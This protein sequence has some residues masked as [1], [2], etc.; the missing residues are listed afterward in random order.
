MSANSVSV[1]DKD[2]QEEVRFYC[3]NCNI[4]LCDDCI[5]GPHKNH[6]FIKLQEFGTQKKK[7]KQFIKYFERYEK[8]PKFRKLGLRF[9]KMQEKC[10][11]IEDIIK[12]IESKGTNLLDTDVALYHVALEKLFEHDP[13]YETVPNIQQLNEEIATRNKL[14]N[15]MGHMDCGKYEVVQPI[16]EETIP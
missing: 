4:T 5:T 13:Y 16:E 8:N 9:V 10:I 15:V 11:E 1:C 2:G 3:R 14:Q 6:D 7:K 12:T